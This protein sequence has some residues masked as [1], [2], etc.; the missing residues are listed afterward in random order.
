MK[1][2]R[3]VVLCVLLLAGCAGN[4]G[5][6]ALFMLAANPAATPAAPVKNQPVLAVDAVWIAPYLDAG[7]IVY[8]TGPNR[9]VIADHNRWAAPLSAQLTNGLY[10]TLSRR[11]SKV[12]IQ[13][14]PIATGGAAYHLHTVVD[15][16][17][18]RYDGN[19]HIAGQWSLLDARGNA[20]AGRAFERK[21]PLATDGYP[22]LVASLSK[23][24]RQ[25]SAAIATAI[26][27]TLAKRQTAISVQP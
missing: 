23:G 17:Q 9:I 11:L 5:A 3:T 14:S 16:F 21:V 26:A 10:A 25:T 2:A 24:W 20:I 8:Q 7:G 13:K 4:P 19:A 12:S 1:I 22:A 18:G 27:R 6:P 15:T